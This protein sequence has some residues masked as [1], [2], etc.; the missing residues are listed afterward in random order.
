MRGIGNNNSEPNF[1]A[2]VP[3]TSIVLEYSGIVGY[4]QDTDTPT[5]TIPLP[6][7]TKNSNY[8][9]SVNGWNIDGKGRPTD[10]NVI[11]KRTNSFMLRGSITVPYLTL[12]ASSVNVTITFA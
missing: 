4:A 3:G 10:V 9:V 2:Q 8:S 1:V 5:V 11:N 7:V 6:F 12:C